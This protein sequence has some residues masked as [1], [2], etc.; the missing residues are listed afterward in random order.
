MTYVLL[1]LSDFITRLKAKIPSI[2]FNYVT[3]AP[4]MMPS[5]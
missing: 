3:V 1:V 5:I 4:E 2:L